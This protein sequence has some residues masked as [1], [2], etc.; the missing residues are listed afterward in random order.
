MDT[1]DTPIVSLDAQFIETSSLFSYELQLTPAA[2]RPSSIRRSNSAVRSIQGHEH[3]ICCSTVTSMSNTINL[4][5]SQCLCAICAHCY[6]LFRGLSLKRTSLSKLDY[7]SQ[8]FVLL[9][10]HCTRRNGTHVIER[11]ASQ[12]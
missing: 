12:T 10:T 3:E 4:K 9:I 2:L 5:P 7:V 6:P 8:S 1:L 11:E